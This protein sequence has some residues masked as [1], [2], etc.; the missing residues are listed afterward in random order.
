MK[1]QRPRPH[2]RGHYLFL[3]VAAFFWANGHCLVASKC[4]IPL[5]SQPLQTFCL[6]QQN[7]AKPALATVNLSFRYALT[8][9]RYDHCTS[10]YAK[11]R[12]RPNL[13]DCVRNDAP[14]ER[15]RLSHNY[16]GGWWV[17][18]VQDGVEPA[19]GN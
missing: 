8:E 5:I 2:G 16:C 13:N 18:L 7:T 11:V 6:C 15:C 12:V 19:F 3:Y 10:G 4:R 1:R 14:F 9:P 17:F